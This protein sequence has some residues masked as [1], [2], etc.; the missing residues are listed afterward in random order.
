MAG[1]IRGQ[2]GDITSEP[3]IS[4]L[5]FKFSLGDHQL[6]WFQYLCWSS[7]SPCLSFS[8]SISSRSP[9]LAADRL[10]GMPAL[11]P[12]APAP[13]PAPAPTSALDQSGLGGAGQGRAASGPEGGAWP[14]AREEGPA[15]ARERRRTVPAVL[16]RSHGAGISRL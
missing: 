2:E 11:L 15:S 9:G 5:S 1:K 16:N 10:P 14:A 6:G 7:R 12:E 3:P 13:A 4:F 8:P